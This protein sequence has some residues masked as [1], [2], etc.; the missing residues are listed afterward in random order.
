VSLGEPGEPV[1]PDH[2]S[3]VETQRGRRPPRIVGWGAGVTGVREA[4]V[5]LRAFDGGVGVSVFLQRGVNLAW[6]LSPRIEWW[7][8]PRGQT[9]TPHLNA[10]LLG[11][12]R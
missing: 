1:E 3:E 12:R 5:S 10:R 7:P 8:V 6:S 11:L 9:T 2:A 4:G